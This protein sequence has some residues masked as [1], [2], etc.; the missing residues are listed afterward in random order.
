MLLGTLEGRYTVCNKNAQNIDTPFINWDTGQSRLSKPVYK[1]TLAMR[2]HH[3]TIQ[4]SRPEV[5]PRQLK[6]IHCTLYAHCP[7]CCM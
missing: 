3:Q 1:T 6:R 4:I 5:Y 2:K 7:K